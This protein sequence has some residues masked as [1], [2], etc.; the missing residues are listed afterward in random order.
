MAIDLKLTK[1]ISIKAP[2]AVVWDAL[3]NPEMIKQYLYGTTV[4]SDWKL[5]SELLFTGKWEGKEYVDKGKIMKLQPEKCFQYS[6]WSGF[7]GLADK[8][9][10]YMVITF[11]IE[12]EGEGTLLKLTQSNFNNKTQYEHSDKGWDASFGII[13]KILE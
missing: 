12:K 8:P 7:S 2:L 5:G 10:N 11:E 9:E 6:Y 4:I 3:V 13:K 1:Q